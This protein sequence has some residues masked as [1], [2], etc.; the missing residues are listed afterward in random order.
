MT[1]QL[2]ERIYE[3]FP[4]DLSPPSKLRDE[5]LRN[6]ECR[7]LLAALS[8]KEWGDI[9]TP[10]KFLAVFP[11]TSGWVGCLPVEWF[12]YYLPAILIVAH[13]GEGGQ[14]ENLRSILSDYLQRT[15]Y[16]DDGCKEILN[17]MEAVF[18]NE[19]LDAVT[20]FLRLHDLQ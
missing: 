8:G 19:Q 6:W 5:D 7:E 11:D 1:D 17:Q 10:E 14:F 3:V 13:S 4:R 2:I 9:A 18:T 20:L 15:K 16:S 12:L